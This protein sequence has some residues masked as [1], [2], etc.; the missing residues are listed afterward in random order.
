MPPRLYTTPLRI[1]TQK[2]AR[3]QF[4]ELAEVDVK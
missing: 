2:A 4:L 1:I 3:K